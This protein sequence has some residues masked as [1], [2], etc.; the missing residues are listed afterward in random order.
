MVSGS[1]TDTGVPAR[2]DGMAYSSSRMPKMK[3]TDRRRVKDVGK[4]WIERR[5]CP[6]KLLL[7]GYGVKKGD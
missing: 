4:Q 7:Q 1:G 6:G 2:K 3:I 5:F